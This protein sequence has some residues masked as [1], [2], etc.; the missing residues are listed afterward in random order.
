[1]QRVTRMMKKTEKKAQYAQHQRKRILVG[2]KGRAQRSAECFSGFNKNFS[3]DKRKRYMKVT[4]H[5]G[6]TGT[7]DDSPSYL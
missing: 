5:R 4:L 1:M 2:N 6:K 3:G 7:T